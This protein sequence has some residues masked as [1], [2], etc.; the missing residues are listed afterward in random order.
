[1]FYAE[2]DYDT[3]RFHQFRRWFSGTMT[4]RLESFRQH[5]E[6][7]RGD[8]SQQRIPTLEMLIGSVVRYPGGMADRAQ[9]YGIFAA[10][11]KQRGRSENQFLVRRYRS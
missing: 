8:G 7:G 9:R 6:V 11:I 3:E 10:G 4:D 2:V 1:M 5:H